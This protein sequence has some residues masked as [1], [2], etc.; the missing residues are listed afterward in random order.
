MSGRLGLQ[1]PDSGFCL[2][3]FLREDFA[4][5]NERVGHLDRYVDSLMRLGRPIVAHHA[6]K[7]VGKCSPP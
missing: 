1:L 2:Q 3:A 6:T 7:R 5:L 4:T